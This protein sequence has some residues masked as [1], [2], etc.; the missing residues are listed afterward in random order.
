MAGLTESREILLFSACVSCSYFLFVC[1]CWFC[2]LFCFFVLLFCS[3]FFCFVVVV[4]FCFCFVVVC[5]IGFL[6]YTLYL[7]VIG[8]LSQSNPMVEL[9]LFKSPGLE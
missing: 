4:L 8:S 7:G 3:D 1:C 9:S 5:L 6:F 2:I